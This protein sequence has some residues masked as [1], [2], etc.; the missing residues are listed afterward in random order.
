[1]KTEEVTGEKL[2]EEDQKRIEERLKL[3][4]YFD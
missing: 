4:G 2:T 1:M 3:L